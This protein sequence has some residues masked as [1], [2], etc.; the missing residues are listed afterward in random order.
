[1]EKRTVDEIINSLLEY[2]IEKNWTAKLIKFPYPPNLKEYE[3]S[4][5]SWYGVPVDPTTSNTITLLC[6][7]ALV[8][9]PVIYE[10]ESITEVEYDTLEDSEFKNWE[11]LL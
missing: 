1:M 10:E 11:G 6:E 5:S 7:E 4:L 9:L 3:N 8:S 2:A